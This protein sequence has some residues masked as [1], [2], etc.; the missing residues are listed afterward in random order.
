MAKTHR[1]RKS[2]APAPAPARPAPVL[3]AD[4]AAADYLE[5]IGKR[6]RALRLQRRLSPAA[7][8]DLVRARGQKLSDDTVANYESGSTNAKLLTLREMAAVLDVPLV[9]L[10]DDRAN[11]DAV[12]GRSRGDNEGKIVGILRTLAPAQAE[13]LVK[14]AQML[15]GPPASNPRK[16]A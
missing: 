12:S 7:L 16:A 10:L 13:L 4:F 8:A 15:A 14:Y 9:A 3:R 1:R 11:F 5:L 6:L 2:A